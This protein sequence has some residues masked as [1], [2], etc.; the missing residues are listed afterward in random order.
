M[1]DGDN[2][3][4]EVQEEMLAMLNHGRRS[5]LAVLD[6]TSKYFYRRGEILSAREKYHGVEDYHQ[7]IGNLDARQFESM[8]QSACDLR[9]NYAILF[10]KLTKNQK[11]LAQ[12][13]GEEED[14]PPLI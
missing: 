12:P 1:G 11:K 4:V 7:C 10:D 3:G 13:R 14:G 5:G 2:F 6:A 8:R 9:N